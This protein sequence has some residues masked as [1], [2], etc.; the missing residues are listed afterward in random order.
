V[1]WSFVYTSFVRVGCGNSITRLTW[2]FTGRL[3][4]PQWALPRLGECVLRLVQWMGVAAELE[5]ATGLG[6]DDVEPLVR[7]AAA[8]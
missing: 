1:L 7:G 8:F 2:E 5:D 4:T 6:R 3:A